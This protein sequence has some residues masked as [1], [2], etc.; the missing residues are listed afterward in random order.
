MVNVSNKNK[1]TK[2]AINIKSTQIDNTAYN[3]EYTPLL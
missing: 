3:D 1:L 2:I